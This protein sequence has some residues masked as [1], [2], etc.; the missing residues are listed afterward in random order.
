MLLTKVYSKT[1]KTLTLVSYKEIPNKMICFFLAVVVLQET[2]LLK[3]KIFVSFFNG[4]QSEKD[5]ESTWHTCQL[6]SNLCKI[7]TVSDKSDY[8]RL[9]T[10]CIYNMYPKGHYTYCFK[11]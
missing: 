10:H 4:K 5:F 1:N 8:V 11:A 7:G 3:L 6:F 9:K 2:K